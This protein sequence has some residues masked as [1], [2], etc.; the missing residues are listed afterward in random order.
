MSQRKLSAYW[1]AAAL[2]LLVLVPLAAQADTSAVSTV[3][4]ALAK[5]AYI[6]LVGISKYSDPQIVS[7]AHPED[8]I[9]A[10]YDLFTDKRYLGADQ[11]HIRLLL[12]SPDAQRAS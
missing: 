6:V 5:H 4:D 3:N 10:Y 2:S 11:D 1:R 8:D 12:G 7:R 9:K